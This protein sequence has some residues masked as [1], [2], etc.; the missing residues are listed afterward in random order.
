MILMESAWLSS[1]WVWITDVL[2]EGCCRGKNDAVKAS[3]LEVIQN[4]TEHWNT[5]W[6]WMAW[7][8]LFKALSAL[9]ILC[10]PRINW[11]PLY[12]DL[13]KSCPTCRVKTK[14]LC[15]VAMH[16]VGYCCWVGSNRCLLS[17]LCWLDAAP[18]QTRQYQQHACVVT[19]M[20]WHPGIIGDILLA[21]VLFN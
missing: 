6:I 14:V 12:F 13:H 2:R 21:T 3:L 11:T 15:A 8:L 20:R 5:C 17:S 1:W 18:T 10:L 19:D 9:I 16:L 7:N 4:S